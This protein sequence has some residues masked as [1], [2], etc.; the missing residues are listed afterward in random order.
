[1]QFIHPELNN[2]LSF[3]DSE[4]PGAHA[5]IKKIFVGGIKDDTEESHL[6]DYF[7]KYGDIEIIEVCTFP[8]KLAI[9]LEENTSMV[10]KSS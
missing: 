5:S 6:K 3:Q 1:M 8:R 2:L 10:L 4:R 7:S 9:D